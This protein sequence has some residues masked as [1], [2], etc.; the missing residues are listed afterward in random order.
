[1]RTG[2]TCWNCRRYRRRTIKARLKFVSN[3]SIRVHSVRT[4]RPCVRPWPSTQCVDSLHC[5]LHTVDFTV[6]TFHSMDSSQ[7]AVHSVGRQFFVPSQCLRV[8]Q[9]K[10]TSSVHKL[11]RKSRINFCFYKLSVCHSGGIEFANGARAFS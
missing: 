8:W 10:S 5:G 9:P 11:G 3:R 7:C 1:M 4:M 2:R 6:W